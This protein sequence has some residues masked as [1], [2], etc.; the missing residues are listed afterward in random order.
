[1][2]TI[3]WVLI[4]AIALFGAAAAVSRPDQSIGG[5]QVVVNQV[6]GALA[7]GDSVRVAQGDCVF[8]DE[9]VRTDAD[10]TAK[11][12]LRDNTGLSLGPSSSIKLDRFVY[13]G[14]ERPGAVAV[15]LLK[16]ALRFATGDANKEAYT[17]TTPTASIGVRGTILR[18]EATAAKTIVTL[19]EGAAI[20]CT[21]SKTSRLCKDLIRPDQQAIATLTQVSLADPPAGPGQNGGPTGRQFGSS[22]GNSTGS[23]GSSNGS[24]PSNGPSSGAS[25]GGNSPSGGSSGGSSTGGGSSSGGSTGGSPSSGGGGGVD[26]NGNGNGQGNGGGQG[27]G[28]GGNNGHGHGG[29]GNSGGH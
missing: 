23:A 1:L 17:I 12:L 11:I 16:G 22:I 10:S 28:E 19:E 2:R 18:I 7:S 3:S 25:P 8:R 13:S 24:S 15:N 9:S 29:N 4:A 5:A 27:V 21:R 6:Q 26:G 14:A 20:V